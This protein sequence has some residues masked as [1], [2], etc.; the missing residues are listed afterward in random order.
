MLVGD[1]ASRGTPHAACTHY[2]QHCTQR[3]PARPHGLVLAVCAPP[4]ALPTSLPLRPACRTLPAELRRAF[5]RHRRHLFIQIFPQAR[6]FVVQF[7]P[8]FFEFVHRSSSPDARRVSGIIGCVLNPQGG[9]LA[10]PYHW[11]M[12]LARWKQIF[13][14]MFGGS[15]EKRPQLCPAAALW[16]ASTLIAAT[17]AAPACASPSPP[18]AKPLRILRRHAPV[19][20]VVLMSMCSCSALH[21]PLVTFGRQP[22]S[23]RGM[24]GVELYRL[25]RSSLS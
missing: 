6:N 20:V 11:Q 18:G 10:L 25:E 4:L 24:S 21:A 9:R 13:G 5:L 16:S 8:E 17:S 19:T 7:P 22:R 12:R 1:G 14:G 3:G 15:G 2:H 23:I